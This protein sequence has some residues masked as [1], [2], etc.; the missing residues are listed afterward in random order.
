MPPADNPINSSVDNNTSGDLSKEDILD[1]LMD[2]A[3]TVDKSDKTD[4]AK[5]EELDLDVKDES[6]ESDSEETETE[7]DDSETEE[8]DKPIEEIELKEDDELDYKDVPKRQEILKAYPDIFKKFPGV[9]KAIYREQQYA[10][11]F[12]TIADAKEAGQRL[13]TLK[14]FEGELLSGSIERVLASVKSTDDSAFQKITSGLLQTLAKVDEK[15]YY[16]TLNFVIKNALHSAYTTGKQGD[17]EQLQIA[18]QLLHKYIYGSTNV[19]LLPAGTKSEEPNPKEI[20]L[21]NREKSFASQ[22]LGLA[23]NDITTR[24][25]NVIKSAIDKNIDPRGVMTPYVKNK[26]MEDVI[27]NVQKEI[28]SDT[29]F[30]AIKD[31]LW[32]NAIKENFSEASKVKIRNALLSKAKTVLPGIIQKVKAD[33]LKGQASR[34]RGANES[35]DDKPVTQGKMANSSNKSSGG[36]KKDPSKLTSLEFLMQD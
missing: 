22:Q 20:E 24:T 3:D 30:I 4:K 25:D 28:I 7:N 21:N 16:G 2:G 15:A 26:A 29:R 8:E 13:N 6:D 1:V 23:V 32:E 10:E 17:D 34:N 36:S 18:A 5:D 11:V 9:E 14:E 12:P 27:K 35:K 19:T 31:K 33:A